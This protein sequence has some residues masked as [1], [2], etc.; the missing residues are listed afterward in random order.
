MGKKKAAKKATRRVKT[1]PGR[2]QP[3]ARRRVL[4]TSED[5]VKGQVAIPVLEHQLLRAIDAYRRKYPSVTKGQILGALRNT[6][7]AVEQERS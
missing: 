6:L 1:V 5:Q 3:S 4:R 2:K 7:R